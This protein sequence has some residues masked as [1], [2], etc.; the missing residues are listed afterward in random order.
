MADTRLDRNALRRSRSAPDVPLESSRQPLTVILPAPSDLINGPRSA[1][2][3]HSF[4]YGQGSELSTIAP[5]GTTIASPPT[6]STSFRETQAVMRTTPAAAQDR[7][8][9]R[10]FH[11]HRSF[12]Y[13]AMIYLGYGR[14]ASPNRKI[15]VSLLWNLLWGFAQIVTII[16]V[17]AYAASKESPVMTGVNEWAACSRPLGVWSCLWIGRVFVACILSYWG[18][19]RDRTARELRD[20]PEAGTSNAISEASHPATPPDQSQGRNGRASHQH[21]SNSSASA[22]TSILPHTI[23]FRRLSLFSSL[24]SLSWFLTAHILVYTSV[25]SCRWSSPHLWWLVFSIL[26]IT[27]LMILEVVVLGLVIFIIGPFILLLWNIF[28][29]CVGRHPLQNPH[30]IKPEIGKLPKSAV[31][32]IPLV[33]Y[34]PPP[35]DAPPAEGPIKSPEAAH[36]YPPKPPQ[37]SP[38]RSK[39]RFKYI[40]KFSKTKKQNTGDEKE[41][42]DGVPHENKEDSW[43]DHWETEGYPFVV[44]DNNRAA[45]AICLMDFEEPKRI[46]KINGTDTQETLAGPNLLTNNESIADSQNIAEEERERDPATMRLEDAG[47]GAQ[48][49][50]LLACGHVFHKT[51]LDPWLIDVSGRCPVCQRRVEVSESK[52]KKKG[53]R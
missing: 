18:W 51:C 30:M 3:S 29:I 15:F 53:A 23:L 39:R 1:G 16:G 26:C 22:D 32:R 25:N 4:S 52:K 48:P 28:L 27:Y 49:L 34:I 20:D 36:L 13:R 2:P 43:E 33:M 10:Q 47:V 17:L 19:R 42:G 9:P 50:R 11:P 37:V 12:I 8:P 38:S 5:S 41:A 7:P 45:C 40:R 35:P 24:Y 46:S 14:G 6:A 31:D 44:L 21:G